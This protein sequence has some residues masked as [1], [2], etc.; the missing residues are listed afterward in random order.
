MEPIPEKPTNNIG[1]L[2]K[3]FHFKGSRSKK[4]KGNDQF[5]QALYQRND[6]RPILCP[7]RKS[8]I[9]IYIYIY[10]CVCVWI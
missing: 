1:D 10:I 4:C 8:I 2:N 9:Y 6:Q 7:S 3:P 5:F